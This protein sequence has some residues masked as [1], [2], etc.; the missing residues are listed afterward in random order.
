MKSFIFSQSTM[1]VARV[2]RKQFGVRHDCDDFL[3]QKMSFIGVYILIYIFWIS[4]S[5]KKV[6]R[7]Q[8][9]SVKVKAV[10]LDISHLWKETRSDRSCFWISMKHTLRIWNY[11]LSH[12]SLIYSN[13]KWFFAS[14][15]SMSPLIMIL[16]NWFENQQCS[17]STTQFQ[18][19]WQ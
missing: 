19:N 18:I 4:G 14:I 9:C 7:L 5:T 17:F 6:I 2:P 3:P 8:N 10:W 12:M 1:K 15:S 13:I 11:I 16:P